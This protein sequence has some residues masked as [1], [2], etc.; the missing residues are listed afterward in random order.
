MLPDI[1]VLSL[2]E[3]KAMNLMVKLNRDEAKGSL[4]ISRERVG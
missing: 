4:L 3:L 1:P 2:M